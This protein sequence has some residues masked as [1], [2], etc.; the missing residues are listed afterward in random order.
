MNIVNFWYIFTLESENSSIFQNIFFLID[1]V[2]YDD[3][4]PLKT[5][6]V[7]VLNRAEARHQESCLLS[8]KSQGWDLY[9]KDLEVH[10]HF[11]EMDVVEVG[12]YR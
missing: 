12:D 3:T 7:S 6:R 5:D 8:F 2:Y 10:I 11:H 1:Q 9:L 4:N